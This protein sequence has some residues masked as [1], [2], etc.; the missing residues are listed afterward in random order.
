MNEALAAIARYWDTDAATDGA[1]AEHGIRAPAEG[2]AWA[3]VLV[4]HMPPQPAGVLDVGAG[5]GFLSLLAARLGH[6]VTA[7]GSALQERGEALRRVVGGRGCGVVEQGRAQVAGH[8]VHG[9]R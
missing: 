4:R 1:G 9:E 8:P 2:A 5:T 7:L 3:A 6:Q